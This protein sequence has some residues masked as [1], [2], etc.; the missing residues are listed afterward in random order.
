LIGLRTYQH[1]DI[2]NI[3]GGRLW[4][5]I[6]YVDDVRA[7]AYVARLMGFEV[8]TAVTVNFIIYR[9]VTPCSAVKIYKMF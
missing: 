3:P 8:V 2:V 6:E 9:N 1:P 5:M 7:T 4:N